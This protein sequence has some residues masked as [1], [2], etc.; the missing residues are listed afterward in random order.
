VLSSGGDQ[1]F[2][3]GLPVGTVSKVSVGKELFL[4]IQVKPAADLSRLEEV[5]V[6]TEKREREPVAESGSRV[7]A[8]DIL[9]QRLPSVPDKLA[10][11]A[12]ATPGTSGA[13]VT[14]GKGMT[15]SAK[16]VPNGAGK[17]VAA[18]GTVPA[19]KLAGDAQAS[20][21][22]LKKVAQKTAGGESPAV[23]SAPSNPRSTPAAN[24]DAPK[25]TSNPAA[26]PAKPAADGA[27]LSSAPPNPQPPATEDSPH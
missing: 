13:S 8:A 26:S 9:A 2:P 1:I 6:V 21:V 24:A 17:P 19:A 4:N 27:K 7:R 10:V 22:G 11:V 15:A 23:L 14:A 18:T 20:G 3:K 16:P 25:A 5:L 12:G